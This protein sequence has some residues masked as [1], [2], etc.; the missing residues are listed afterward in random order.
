MINVNGNIV[1]EGALM[2]RQPQQSVCGGGHSYSC[3]FNSSTW[4]EYKMCAKS[5]THHLGPGNVRRHIF[6]RRLLV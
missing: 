2:T 4:L 5:G 1:N 3:C 6:R